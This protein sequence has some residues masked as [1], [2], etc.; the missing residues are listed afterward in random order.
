MRKRAKNSMRLG[1]ALGEEGDS[2]IKKRVGR[3]GEL[4]REPTTCRQ[5]M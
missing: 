1:V 4:F 5:R 3:E 2:G